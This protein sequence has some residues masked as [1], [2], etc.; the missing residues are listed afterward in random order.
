MAHTELTAALD[1]NWDLYVGADGSLM[2]KRGDAATYQN[3]A[4]ECRCST[5]DL[6]FDQERGIPWLENHLG[7]RVQ[8]ALLRSDLRR[9]AMS[10]KGVKS[11][12]DISIQSLDVE[13]RQLHGVI[14]VLTDKDTNG[15]AKV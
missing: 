12:E 1:E 5:K 4:N 3:V 8:A 6:Y 2:T 13:T 7:K 11:V 15:E 10:V 9:A 14:R